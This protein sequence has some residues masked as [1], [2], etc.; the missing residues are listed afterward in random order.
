[1]KIGI[2]AERANLAHPTGVER[3][4]AELIRHLARIDHTNEYILYFRTEPQE[5]FR[6]LPPNFKIKVIPFPKFW[7]QIRISWEMYRHPV[8]VLMILAS[9]L[10]LYH[11]KNTIVTVHDI[12]FELYPELFTWFNRTYLKFF[13]RYVTRVATKIVTVSEA[14]KKDLVKH[15][16]ANPDKIN[17]IYLGYDSHV[18]KPLMY[19]QVQ[20]V[21]DEYGLSYK[22]YLMFVGT[23]QPR[24]NIIRLVQAYEKIASR[25]HIEEKLVIVGKKGWMWGPILKEIETSECKERIKVLDYAPEEHLPALY[26][27]ASLLTL[28]SMYEG[29]G[30]PPLE[31]MACG[32]P[33]VVSN[34]SSLPEVVGEAGELVD[35][36]SVDS[37]ADGL[38]RVLTDRKLQE[39]LSQ[40]GRNRAKQFSWETCARKTLK[41]I[42][43]LE[44]K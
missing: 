44:E 34:I 30:I 3:Y 32:T 13:S 35:P 31:A 40:L 1:M 15:Y 26:N 41:L 22:K 28:P 27:G 10:P 19:E 42:E 8:D 38:L 12:A 5:W 43:S 11:P 36:N 24:K 18:Y 39:G 7:T 9:A 37:I 20:G 25:H 2:E 17:V 21:L 6:Q 16:G 14:T 4:A 23:L 29:F 33:V